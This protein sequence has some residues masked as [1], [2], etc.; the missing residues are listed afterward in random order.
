MEREGLTYT[1]AASRVPAVYPEGWTPATTEGTEKVPRAKQPTR[2]RRKPFF[3]LRGVKRFRI[4]LDFKGGVLCDKC[5]DRERLLTWGDC[6]ATATVCWSDGTHDKMICHPECLDAMYKPRI[7]REY[8]KT[9]VEHANHFETLDID[10]LESLVSPK[11]ESLSPTESNSTGRECEFLSSEDEPIEVLSPVDRQDAPI[12]EEHE[13]L[14]PQEAEIA[15]SIIID[16]LTWAEIEKKFNISHGTLANRMT[17]IRA[18][19]G[20]TGAFKQP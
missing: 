8:Y 17:H 2:A 11:A 13:E 10:S 12:H 5:K 7:Q 19:L 15:R 3:Q 4:P 18:K 14:T 6:A 1:E 20:I 16:K 9:V